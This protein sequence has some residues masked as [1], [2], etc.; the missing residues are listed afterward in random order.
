MEN[1]YTFIVMIGLHSGAT[2]YHQYEADD[3]YHAME[4]YLDDP[5]VCAEDVKLISFDDLDSDKV[6]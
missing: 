4:Q 1:L 3:I 6:V 2:S 5:M